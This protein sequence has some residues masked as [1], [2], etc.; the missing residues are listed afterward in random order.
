[1][2]GGYFGRVKFERY[3]FGENRRPQARPGDCDIND[4]FEHG[5][6]SLQFFPIA[7]LLYTAIDCFGSANI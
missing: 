6:P 1:M 5:C 4:F 3:R 2:N 7:L